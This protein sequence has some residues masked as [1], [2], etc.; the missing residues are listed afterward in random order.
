MGDVI[1]IPSHTVYLA[2]GNSKSEVR[3]GSR[4]KNN[5]K[6]V[7]KKI[8]GKEHVYKGENRGLTLELPE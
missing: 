6:I 4:H 8:G 3:G 1:S 7:F 2:H 5:S